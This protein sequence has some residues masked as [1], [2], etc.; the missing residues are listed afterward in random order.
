MRSEWRLGDFR[1]AKVLLVML[2]SEL[3]GGCCACGLTLLQ[4]IGRSV[5][6]KI[7][8]GCCCCRGL[9]G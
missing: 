9:I 3:L 5:E 4:L 7:R 8:G 2:Q 1:I 6:V